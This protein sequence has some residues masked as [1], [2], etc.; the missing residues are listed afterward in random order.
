MYVYLVTCGSLPG[1]AAV[2]CL[3]QHDNSF[4]DKLHQQVVFVVL[5]L[6]TRIVTSVITEQAPVTLW[7]EGIPQENTSK[8]K[9]GARIYYS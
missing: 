4:S 3:I 6:L 5:T 1:A 9:R 2:L 7:S 8:T